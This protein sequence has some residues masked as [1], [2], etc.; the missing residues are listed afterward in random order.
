MK[1]DEREIMW[2]ELALLT[3]KLDEIEESVE[4]AGHLL[5]KCKEAILDKVDELENIIKWVNKKGVENENL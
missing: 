4:E 5:M 3:Q 2:E 1:K